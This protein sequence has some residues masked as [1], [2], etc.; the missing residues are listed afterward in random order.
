[1]TDITDAALTDWKDR[2]IPISG[3]QPGDLVTVRPQ[4]GGDVEIEIIRAR[5]D[6][7]PVEWVEIGENQVY[8]RPDVVIE[9][10]EQR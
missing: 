10:R 5:D 9:I 3:L 4:P 8:D 7:L 2:S 1:M 6:G